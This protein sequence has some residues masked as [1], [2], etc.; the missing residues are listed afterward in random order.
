MDDLDERMELG[1]RACCHLEAE[2]KRARVTY[3]E[4][5]QRL[6]KQGF[7]GETRD[8][9]LAKLK[10]GPFAATFLLVCMTALGFD[11]VQLEEIYWPNH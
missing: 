8:S 9:I 1:E 11:G 5:A 6:E 7:I 3:E 10:R 2:M 4:L